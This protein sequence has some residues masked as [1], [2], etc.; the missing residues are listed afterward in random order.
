MKTG[1]TIDPKPAPRGSSSARRCDVDDRQGRAARL[2]G[3]SGADLGQH[4]GDRRAAA[5]RDD[6]LRLRTD[7]ESAVHV[8]VAGGLLQVVR[9]LE[10]ADVEG[11]GLTLVEC[12]AHLLD[13]GRRSGHSDR[14]VV[15]FTAR[16]GP[17][18][19]QQHERNDD[20]HADDDGDEFADC[21]GHD[22]PPEHG[23]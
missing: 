2:R 19:H 17:D 11:S 16:R 18:E 8:A 15:R 9:G 12:G 10:R 14:D 21:R 4:T 7:D 20:G 22:R 3:E 23:T 1:I 6:R 5:G 13:R